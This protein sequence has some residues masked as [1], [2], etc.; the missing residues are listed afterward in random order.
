MVRLSQTPD[1]TRSLNAV[2]DGG[3][4]LFDSGSDRRISDSL[5]GIPAGTGNRRVFR[6]V[7]AALLLILLGSGCAAVPDSYL[8]AD[9]PNRYQ[10]PFNVNTQTIDYSKLSGSPVDTEMISAG[11]QL[12]VS[13]SAGVATVQPLS[14]PVRVASNGYG[15]VDILGPVRLAGLELDEAE[16]YIR[17][18][19]MR[20]Q[21]YVNPRVTVA[22]KRKKVHQ[23]MVVGAVKE[24]GQKAI[25]AAQANLLNAIF[26]AGGLTEDAGSEVEIVNL[27]SEDGQSEQHASVEPGGISQSGYASNVHGSA[28]I[29]LV[30]AT[31]KGSNGYYIG[32][33]GVVY[34]QKRDPKAIHVSGL[35]RKPGKIE[36]P[37]NQDLHLLDAL[38]LAGHT[39]TQVA[40]KVFVFR[41]LPDQ[42]ERV[43]I[44]CSISKIKK[45]PIDNIRLAPGDVVYVEHT[46]ATVLLE[47]LQVIRIGVTGSVNPLL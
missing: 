18:E 10:A 19:G 38:A 1:G 25:P 30:E 46:V 33:G 5:P 21:I 41:H 23:I 47:A 12:E 13:I 6:P 31:E 28:K 17:T 22:M 29:D 4:A 36:F 34:V 43:R 42:A 8:A 2:T 9:L 15:N 40:D 45:S 35:V 16:Q 32:D 3:A 24:P 11:D 27:I 26:A 37:V 44:Q 20:Q 39:T 7:F 14:F